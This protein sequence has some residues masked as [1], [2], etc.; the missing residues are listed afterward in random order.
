[1]DSKRL[2]VAFGASAAILI[3]WTLLFPPAKP[4][5][6]AVAPA[7][8]TKGVA[9][10]E[11]PATPAAPAVPDVAPAASAAAAP[12]PVAVAPVVASS[13]RLLTVK[14]GVLSVRLS[15]RGGEVVSAVL[16]RFRG[17][18]DEEAPLELVRKDVPF[19]GRT[20]V[21]DP[22]DPFLARAGAALHETTV[23]E[24]GNEV[25]VR[26][27]YRESDGQ[28]VTRTYTFGTG[29]VVGLRVEREG[30]GRAT[31]AVVLGPGVGNPTE[32]ELANRYTKP[33]SSVTLSGSRSVSRKAKDGLKEPV[34]L[35][36]GFL[37]A[38][39]EDNYFVTAF[40]PGAKEAVTLR[41]VSLSAP[42][43]PAKGA[44]PAV[45][46]EPLVETEVVASA[47]GTLE[48]GLYL[49]P[50][51]IDVLATVRPGMEKLIDY[52]WF[53]ILVSPLLWLLKQFHS[54]IPNWGVAI[55]LATV[56]I[57]VVLFPLTWKQL[58]SMKKMS[59]LQPKMEAIRQKWTPKLKSDPQARL[60]MNE[61][62]M[63]LYK[64][65]KVN[66]AGGCLPLLLQMP[67]LIAFYNL[68]SHAIDLRHAPF[69]L[70]IQDLSAKDPYYVTPILMTLTMWLQQ[71]MMPATGDATTRKVMGF[72]PLVFGFMFKDMPSGLVLYWL[73]QN[74]LSIVQQLLLERY[75]DL[76]MRPKAAKKA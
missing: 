46:P 50:K 52:G 64:A 23:E 4:A 40:L 69:A 13:P 71:Q 9:A 39:L 62:T 49:G 12:A 11:S 2:A 34:A 19:A 76:G 35:G 38:G 36:T 31:A 24:G 10:S 44:V 61:E 41:P 1:M 42:A 20:L 51:D 22:A 16:R 30:G 26:F 67:I 59:A 55:I 5:R 48:T 68:L 28:G 60:K 43:G 53:A 74:V 27:R 75:T 63:A 7:S 73:V 21:Y 14:N 72:L 25:V 17:G 33:G 3:L 45:A 66:P 57:K 29:Y 8:P 54:A 32:E 18:H 6:R 58:V 70:W 37:A 47:A 56:V 15:N 65:E